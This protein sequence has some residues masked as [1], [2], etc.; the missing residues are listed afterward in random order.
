MHTRFCIENLKGRDHFK[1]LGI[2]GR[3]ILKYTINTCT[4][5]SAN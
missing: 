2:G 5:K 3:V 4:D 1:G